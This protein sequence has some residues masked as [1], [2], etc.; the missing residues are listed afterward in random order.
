M[1]EL[2]MELVEW[3]QKQWWLTDEYIRV[4]E[5][6]IPQEQINSA[7]DAVARVFN[8]KW[9]M[10]VDAHPVCF[11]LLQQGTDPLHFLISLGRN[12]LAVQK[13]EGF[14]RVQ[15]DLRDPGSYAS[16]SLELSLGALLREAGQEIEFR[17]KLANGRESDI[18]ARSNGQEVFFEVKILRASEVT[19]ALSEFTMWLWRTVDDSARSLGGSIAEMHYEIDLD[20]GLA[21]TFGAGLKADLRFVNG[22]AE[23]TG[24][25][26]VENMRRG[27]LDFFIQDLGSFAFR[28]K[29]MLPNSTIIHRPVSPSA[30][31]GRILRSRF[32][33]AIE[34][35]PQD[36]PGVLVFR[37]A[38]NLEED[39]ARSVIEGF[40]RDEAGGAS[41]ISGVI[42]FPTFY[43]LPSR[44]SP[45][46][47]FA[48]E[49]P[50][51]QFPASSLQA[52][53]TIVEECRLS[54]RPSKRS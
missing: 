29:E 36:H 17:P 16:A 51:A 25:Q 14:G 22:F 50:S 28:P 18:V 27:N 6:K 41:H 37:T 35:I 30:E 21:D 10:S 54:Q 19:E 42:I 43:S 23:K 49:N 34:Q 46:E 24:T 39:Q 5:G 2:R 44:W 47:G 8:K 26:I 31:L 11:F 7:I 38:G 15:K 12:I 48:I 53:R 1:D 32:H 3:R 9:A 52:F 20:I 13:S 45:F 33:G 40:L 4:Y